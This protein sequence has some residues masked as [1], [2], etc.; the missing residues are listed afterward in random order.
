[1]K[2]CSYNFV[3]NEAPNNNDITHVA[4]IEL[5]EAP[6]S[7]DAMRVGNNVCLTAIGAQQ[8]SVAAIQPSCRKAD[9]PEMRDNDMIT[10]KV[11]VDGNKLCP[12]KEWKLYTQ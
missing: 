7:N 10:R 3:L 5:Y 1:M 12:G 2:F 6:Y 11:C 4:N 9:L 8:F